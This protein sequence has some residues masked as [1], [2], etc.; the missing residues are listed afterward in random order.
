MIQNRYI[1]ALVIPVVLCSCIYTTHNYNTGRTLQEGKS[2]ITLGY[3]KQKMIT[4]DCS[5][6][7]RWG[8]L[9]KKDGKAT[10]L[11]EEYLDSTID[12]SFYKPNDHI[13]SIPD[14]SFGYGLG[15]RNNW[16]P[17]PGLEMGFLLEIPTLPISAEFYMRLAMP[18]YMWKKTKHSVAMGYIMG[19][20]ADN[21]WYL[22]YAISHEIGKNLV[23]GSF[24]STLMATQMMD[25]GTE[26]ADESFKFV[27]NRKLVH[28]LTTGFMWFI[29]DIVIFPD[30]V[31]PQIN[32]LYPKIPLTFDSRSWGYDD[33]G[34]YVKWNVGFGWSF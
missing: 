20:W 9:I 29:P 12:S 34:F 18:D 33:G 4:L 2:R 3:G 22:G 11:Y 5:Y 31:T 8:Y 23:Y 15:I 24:R 19:A 26:D 21:S 28:M 7:N 16:G 25:N 30:F 13:Q 10:C 14:L 27:H 17:F 1:L 32:I 6:D